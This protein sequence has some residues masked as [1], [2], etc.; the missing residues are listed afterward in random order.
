MSSSGYLKRQ[1]RV[2]YYPRTQALL[3]PTMIFFRRGALGNETDG[4]LI[5]MD[6]NQ[7]LVLSAI[8]QRVAR[9]TGKSFP[10]ALPVGTLAE[11]IAFDGYSNTFAVVNH[12][13][14]EVFGP[15]VR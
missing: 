5:L 10:N 14:I 7:E 6:R 4:F 1:K 15:K 9:I 2:Y 3:G 8:T 12:N 11:S 13:K